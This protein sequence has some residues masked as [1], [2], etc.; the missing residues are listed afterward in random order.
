MCSLAPLTASVG[1]AAHPSCGSNLDGLIRAA[2]NALY[3]AKDGGRDRVVAAPPGESAGLSARS[4]LRHE[5][6]LPGAPE[7]RVVTIDA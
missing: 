4:S 3:A 6:P 5:P 2:D 1:V 7:L